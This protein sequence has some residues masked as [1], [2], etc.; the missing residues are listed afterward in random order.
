MFKRK[1]SA[2]NYPQVD[3]LN[4]SD[5]NEVKKVILWLEENKIK[6]YKPESRQNI[7]NIN[8][9]EWKKSYDKYKQDLACPIKSDVITDELDWF[10]KYALELEYNSKKATY[11]KHT[12]ENLKSASTPNVIAANPLDHLDFGG[13][14]FESGVKNLAQ[15]LKISPHPNP[16]ITLKAISKVVCNRLSRNA[17]EKPNDF[18]IKGTPFPFED[19][20]LGFDLGD[21]LLNR[22]AKILTLLYI[23]NLRD[24]QTKSNELIV[25]AQSI[26]ANP[27]TDTK[28]G[29]VGK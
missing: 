23:Q 25:A 16:L 7:R 13:K 4:T 5:E 26:T 8:S 6:K 22:A 24:L 15:I 19:A 11:E 10:I 29:K 17:I 12:V 18:I 28:L 1:L 2:L 14:D 20:N 27:K 3:S 21:V 9:S